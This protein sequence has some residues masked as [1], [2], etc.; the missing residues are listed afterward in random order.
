[1]NY[2]IM[3]MADQKY[4][5][6]MSSINQLSTERDALDVVALC[7]EHEVHLLMIHYEALSAEFF[8]LRTK[9]AGDIL[10]KFINYNIKT[11]A[12]IPKDISQKGRFREMAL[13]ANQGNHFRIFDNQSEAEKWLYNLN[14]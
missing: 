5:A 13:E 11:A 3:E 10:Q 7:W 12:V 1:M 6:L 2:E 8:Q 9:A 14:G 4:I